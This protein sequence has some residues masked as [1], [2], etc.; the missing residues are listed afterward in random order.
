LGQKPF[1][2]KTDLDVRLS[3]S[4]AKYQ[5]KEGLEEK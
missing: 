4:Y 2:H 5:N 1:V 3:G